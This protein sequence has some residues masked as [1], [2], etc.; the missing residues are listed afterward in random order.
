MTR[1]AEDL[2]VTLKSAKFSV[3]FAVPGDGQK[4]FG[5]YIDELAFASIY[6]YVV[7]GIDSRTALFRLLRDEP[8][9]LCVFPTVNSWNYCQLKE[10]ATIGASVLVADRNVGAEIL[11]A[12]SLEEMT[13]APLPDAI[14]RKIYSR[15]NNPVAVARPAANLDFPASWATPTDAQPSKRGSGAPPPLV[16]VCV[17][18][19]ERPQLVEQA[20]SSVENQTYSN[21]EVVLVDDGSLNL[22]AI[23][24]LKKLEA[25]FQKK[26]WR[27]VRQPN[28]Y[29]GAAR[30]SAAMVARGQ[31]LYF[32]DD[33]NVLKPNALDTLVGVA[34]KTGADVVA[35]FS[36]V[37]RGNHPP[38]PS[39]SASLRIIQ[40]GDDLSYG[41]FRNAFGDS[42]AL[43]RR[44]TFLSLG[45][46]SEDYAVGLDD[47]E[48]FARTILYGYRLTVVPEALYWAR[49][50]PTRLRSMH[51]NPMAGNIRVCRTYLPHV[52]AKL[53]P[54]FLLISGN[55]K[56]TFEGR[57]VTLRDYRS[58]LFRRMA[59]TRIGS[60]LR[61]SIWRPML[62]KLLV[63]F[64][65]IGN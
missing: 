62:Q 42:N 44:S 60:W 9:T 16:T 64:R 18:H 20:L 14:S 34:E 28:R 22:N 58:S 39:T 13:C 27:V 5:S 29:L 36:D 17:M 19:F 50:M 3:T 52:P 8:D 43:I 45:G 40:V 30:N 7:T 11:A 51:F 57:N 26:G 59:N 1:G 4:K 37:F 46:N 21:F 65:L 35:S 15:L 33:D 31:Y 2:R 55:I 49:Q 10:L 63:R 6:S 23:R 24:K 56:T 38:E 32:L 61:Y 53:R 12:D 54:L 25:Q 41:F 47:M 48:F